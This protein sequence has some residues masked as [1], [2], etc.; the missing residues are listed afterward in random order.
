MLDADFFVGISLQATLNQAVGELLDLFIEEE[1][2]WVV[3]QIGRELRYGELEE[4]GAL[5]EIP[6]EFQVVNVPG[7]DIFGQP[8]SKTNKANFE[9]ECP[10]CK[11][12]LAAARF[13]QHLEKCM[14]MGRNSS[15]IAS[16]RLAAASTA[17]S[18]S[19]TNAGSEAKSASQGSSA[20]STSSQVRQFSYD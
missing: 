20:S 15:R 1:C 3:T 16:R 18:S 17:S 19:A 4:L 12:T 7:L 5:D 9:C 11:R 8:I 10:K 13:A 14:G 2:L 6:E